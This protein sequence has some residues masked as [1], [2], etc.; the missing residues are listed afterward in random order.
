MSS[1]QRF[2]LALNAA[3]I[4]LVSTKAPRAT[5]IPHADSA[6]RTP[7]AFMGNVHSIDFNMAQVIY[8]ENVVPVAEGLRSV[9]YQTFIPPT[10]FNNFDSIFP[11]RDENE[12][13]ILFSPGRGSNYIHNPTT[14]LWAA[15]PSIG[16]IQGRTLHASSIP[17]NSSVTYAYVDGQTFVCYSRLRSS[18]ATPVDMSL[19]RWD[20]V[21]R[22]LVATTTFITN[23]PFAAGTIDGISSS[24]G[25]LIMWSGI[26]VAW[27][28]FDGTS[29]NFSPFA[30]NAFTG[31]GRQIPE[32]IKG[33]ITAI[34]GI[35]GGFVIFTSR[36]AIS[37]TFHA[38][39]V[40]SPWTFREI[41]GVGGLLSY[42]QATV[43]A[44][45]SRLVA[46]TSAGIQSI[47][48]N[49]GTAAHPDVSDF[50]AGRQFEV[51]S[52]AHKDFEPVASAVDLFTK[53]NTIGN[54]Y[55][56]ISYGTFPGIFSFALIYDAQLERWG[57]LKIAHVDCFNYVYPA[58]AAQLTYGMLVDVSYGA[59]APRQY[60]QMSVT[61]TGVTAAQH[62]MAFLLPT[63][64]VRVAAWSNTTVP[65]ENQSTVII[66]RVQLARTRNTQLN[67]IELEGVKDA[68]VFIQASANGRVIDRV[69][70]TTALQRAEDYLEVGCLVDCKNFNI[71]IEGTFNLST[72][73]VEALPTGRL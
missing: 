53:I 48:L 8:A 54:R 19:F 29:F 61:N 40:A 62:S 27:A 4:P 18:D 15:S 13:H 38:N 56:V 2:K 5:V 66:G 33:A 55:L 21:A 58:P 64:E 73:I 7:M 47:N 41:P 50:I 44:T 17:G 6:Q 3:S 57:K 45:L 12:N 26:E 34:L 39:S 24:S 71:V 46:Y 68:N 10:A 30:N 65:I 67:K 32:D 37:A 23:V 31:S 28:A 52:P 51:Y 59:T 9:G 69:I 20:P 35:A 60:D 14:N 49:S 36:N 63:G 72:V 11:L 25:F 1:I 22:T 43:D 70:P 16:T 42:E